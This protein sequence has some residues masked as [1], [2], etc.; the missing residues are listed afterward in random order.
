MRTLRAMCSFWS[1]IADAD[2]FGL[3]HTQFMVKQ[4]DLYYLCDEFDEENAPTAAGMARAER[5]LARAR[6]WTPLGWWLWSLWFNLGAAA[7]VAR[8]ELVGHDMSDGGS[9]FGP[10]SGR[11]YLVC[12]RCGETWSHQW[13]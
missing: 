8:C 12:S 5:F 13:Y 1:V 10:N 4:E 6:N 9:H 7:R 2:N 11:E 3:R